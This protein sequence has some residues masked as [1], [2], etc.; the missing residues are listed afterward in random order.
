VAEPLASDLNRRAAFE[1]LYD[2][3]PRT[4]DTLEVFFAD[5]SLETFGRGGAGWFWWSRRRGFS[6]TGPAAGP[7]PT[8]FAA[9]RDAVSGGQPIVSFGTRSS[10]RQ[11]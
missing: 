3:H 8:S 7:F 10:N 2:I 11:R 4:G 1:P 6:P 5:R 9:F